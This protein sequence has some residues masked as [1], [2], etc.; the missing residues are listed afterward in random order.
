MTLLRNH[1]FIILVCALGL[2]LDLAEFAL[3]TILS[4]YFT[5]SGTLEDRNILPWLL[6]SVYVGAFIGAS[7]SGGLADA[8]G[9]RNMLLT[10]MIALVLTSTAAA[11]APNPFTL[12]ILRLLAGLFLGAYPPLMAA[13]LTETLPAKERGRAIL[14]VVAVGACGP[15]FIVFFVQLLSSSNPLGFA[16]WRWGF[17]ACAAIALLCLHL[18]RKLPESD[19]WLQSAVMVKEIGATHNKISG[20]G[21]ASAAKA[22]AHSSLEPF[23]FILAIFLIVLFFSMTWSTIGF[24][25]LIGSMLVSKGIN[26]QQ[27]LLFTGIASSGAIIGAFA[28]GLVIDKFERKSVLLFAATTMAAMTMIFGWLS[29]P[30]GLVASSIIFNI[31]AAMF[32]PV[33]V[34]Y[35]GELV[36]T[37]VRGRVTSWSWAAR[38]AGAAMVPFVLLPILQE[39]GPAGMTLMIL[40][41]IAFFCFMIFSFGP[42]GKAGVEVQ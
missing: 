33:L 6:S 41:S 23:P 25:L 14:N 26:L 21:D 19:K 4:T 7:I 36:S 3:G 2:S 11:F 37:P 34:I 40:V 32:W 9:R 8:Y 30:V 16:A 18:V 28:T 12:K 39:F 31:L 20:E 29:D 24:P 42:Q 27:S 35:A 10:I 13:Y 38:G 17:L 22:R 5:A 1:H 15:V